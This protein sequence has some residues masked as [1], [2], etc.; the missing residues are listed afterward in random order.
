M[1]MVAVDSVRYDEV[2][3]VSAPAFETLVED[4]RNQFVDVMAVVVVDV[5]VDILN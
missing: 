2:C 4:E 1:M 5:M 3:E